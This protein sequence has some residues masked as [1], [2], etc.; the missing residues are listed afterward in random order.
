M[1]LNLVVLR[2]RDVSALG[3]F[4]QAL[5]LRFALESHGNGPQHLASKVGRATF[6]IYPCSDENATEGLRIGFDVSDVS[7]WFATALANGA[8]CVAEPLVSEWG[9]RAVIRD[10][11]G[12]IVDFVESA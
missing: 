10:P 5:G 3:S 4:Y 9:H 8:A 6:E 2:T 1:N 12:H 11:A 7:E